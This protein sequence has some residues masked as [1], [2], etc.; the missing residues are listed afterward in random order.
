MNG[1]WVNDIDDTRMQIFFFFFFFVGLGF[2]SGLHAHKV[3]TLPL[4]PHLQSILLW[5]FWK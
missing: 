5:L 2:N 3:G 4:E 1:E